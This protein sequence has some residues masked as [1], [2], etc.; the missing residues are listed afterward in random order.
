MLLSSID[1]PG[2]RDV[3]AKVTRGIRRKRDLKTSEVAER[4]G[5]PLRTY[6]LFE[7]GGGRLSLD[8]IRK[9]AEATDSDPFAIILS[10]AFEDAGFAIAC[11]DTKMALILAMHLQG[12][13]EDRGADIAFLEPP[14]IIGAFERIFKELGAKLDDNEAFLRRWFDGR[15]GS[16]SL[17]SLSVRGVRRRK[18]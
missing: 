9:F 8:R 13:Y 18:A 10:V 6:E 7:A 12:F 16:I 14:N 11:A 17:G 4:M 15:T 3:L 2:G 1:C 5:L